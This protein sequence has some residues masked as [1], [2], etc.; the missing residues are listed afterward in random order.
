MTQ[1]RLVYLASADV[2]GGNRLKNGAYYA[3]MRK[4]GHFIICDASTGDL[5]KVTDAI[6]AT[7]FRP[8]KIPGLMDLGV[9]EGKDLFHLETTAGPIVTIYNMARLSAEQ[10]ANV[11]AGEARLKS[12]GKDKLF[13]DGVCISRAPKKEIAPKAE[14]TP[15]AKHE[16]PETAPGKKMD[17]APVTVLASDASAEV[18]RRTRQNGI[19]GG[20][21]LRDLLLK[22]KAMEFAS[23]AKL[24]APTQD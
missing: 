2:V 16:E 1:Y 22:R 4:Q 14:E 19:S 13:P 23:R 5:Y 11:R 24:G 12:E 15:L 10:A 21:G 9:I 3:G 18:G 8:S 20:L 17:A 6:Q 7:S